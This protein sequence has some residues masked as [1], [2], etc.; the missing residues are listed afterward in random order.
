[1]LGDRVLVLPSASST[2]PSAFAD[3]EL[4]ER[5]RQG[6]LRLT[7]IAGI[8]GRPALSVP[9]LGIPQ[10]GAPLPAPLGACLV[11]PRFSDLALIELAEGLR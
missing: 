6:T 5:T 7:A 3:P 11:G 1:V 9:L 2:A 8:T 10:P 4:V